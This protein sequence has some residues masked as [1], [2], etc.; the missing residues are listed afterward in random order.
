MRSVE[1]GAWSGERD[2]PCLLRLKK[3]PSEI[4][5]EVFVDDIKWGTNDEE[6]LKTIIETIGD[7]FT[8]TV[9]D[10]PVDS[11]NKDKIDWTQALISTYLG[12]R[13]THDTSTSGKH[14]LKVDQTTYIDEIIERFELTDTLADRITPLPMGGDNVFKDDKLIGWSKKF[15][16]PMIIGSVIHSLVHTRPDTAYTVSILSRAMS[17]PTLHHYKAARCLLVY[18]RSTQT[19]GIEYHQEGMLETNV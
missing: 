19:L 2:G 17:K 9:G 15:S 11:K 5:A 7:Q 14:V 18:L 10:I 3:G 6:F 12:M 8:T 4:I 1:R 16:Y 13:Y